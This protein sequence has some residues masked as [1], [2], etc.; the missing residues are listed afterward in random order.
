[1]LTKN[2]SFSEF[3]SKD[4]SL[5][6]EHARVQI[7]LLARI[8]QNFRDW[9]GS[10]VIVLSGYRSP[11]HNSNIGGSPNS[12]HLKGKASDL[13]VL[14]LS[15]LELY[16]KIQEAIDLGIIPDG[17]LGFYSWGV[18]YDIRG[19]KARW[20]QDKLKSYD[21]NIKT[22]NIIPFISGVF[23]VFISLF[24]AFKNRKGLGL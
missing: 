13:K 3:E 6:P 9:L 16:R 10:P 11:I 12:Q 21:K 5:M 8:L 1:M 14:G 4:G 7:I 18:H 2:F 20:N 23:T 15:S 22:S 24:F 19:Y 17:G